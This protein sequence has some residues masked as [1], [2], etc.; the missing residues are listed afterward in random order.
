[1]HQ[2]AT[3][4]LKTNSILLLCYSDANYCKHIILNSHVHYT[5]Q[6]AVHIVYTR[7]VP[8]IYYVERKTLLTENKYRLIDNQ[9][10]SKSQPCCKPPPVDL[11]IPTAPTPAST[12]TPRRYLI[13]GRNLHRFVSPSR[14]AS[15]WTPFPDPRQQR[16]PTSQVTG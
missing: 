7:H 11:P 2:V 10:Q 5:I 12:I 15:R 16:E 9:S 6:H 14:Q 3:L 8:L 13:R 1:M 4:T